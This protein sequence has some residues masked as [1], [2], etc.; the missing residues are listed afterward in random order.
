MTLVFHVTV[1]HSVYSVIF[2]V[3]LIIQ[4]GFIYIN[5]YVDKVDVKVN[6]AF[7][8]LIFK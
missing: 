5:I 1:L 2:S 6:T 4:N 3:H 8:V 7:I